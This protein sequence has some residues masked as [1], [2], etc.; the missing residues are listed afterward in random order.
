MMTD[1]RLY[2][3]QFKYLSIMCQDTAFIFYFYIINFHLRIKN[4]YKVFTCNL[5]F[6]QEGLGRP[7]MGA[8]DVCYDVVR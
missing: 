1:L 5:L 2:I 8:G 4:K 3:H 7:V 6:I